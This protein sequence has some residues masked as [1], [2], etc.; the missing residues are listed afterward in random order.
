MLFWHVAQ[1]GIRT[2]P[3]VFDVRAETP[4]L[5][6]PLQVIRPLFIAQSAFVDLIIQLRSL[7]LCADGCCMLVSC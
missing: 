1:L 7:H 4:L 5:R 2:L 3:A 6:P